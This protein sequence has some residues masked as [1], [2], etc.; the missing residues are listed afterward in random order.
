MNDNTLKNYRNLTKTEKHAYNTL[1]ALHFEILKL[2][3]Y[4]LSNKTQTSTSTIN[5]ML[6]KIGYQNLKAYKLD[7]LNRKPKKE[8]IL[9]TD[10]L[11]SMLQYP[12][13]VILNRITTLI[14]KATNVYVCGFGATQGI[15]VELM[16]GLN[17]KKINAVSI[18]D[19]ELLG[20]IKH[21]LTKKD[22][23]IYFSYSGEN[24]NMIKS[25]NFLM[26]KT[27]QILVTCQTN[28]SL[29]QNVDL[30]YNLE[31]EQED[32]DFKVRAPLSIVVYQL[33]TLMNKS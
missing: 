20:V 13:M 28:F 22:I 27:T 19:S 23:I 9:L 12:N 30:V 31:I 5:R 33:L 4:Q 11:M 6:R 14:E 26:R 8:K 21:Q 16:I 24:N 3:I 17:R 32:I 25:T 10:K 1:E 7:L 15:A 2:N 29:S 18:T